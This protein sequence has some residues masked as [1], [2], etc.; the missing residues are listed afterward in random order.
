MK[1][2]RRSA[3]FFEDGIWF[4]QDESMTEPIKKSEP[5]NIDGIVWDRISEAVR[6]LRFGSVEIIVQ[7][8]RVV[9]IERTEKFRLDEARMVRFS[10]GRG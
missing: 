10:S 7:D 1:R 4:S 6:G 2:R 3:D 5:W 8:G 9:Q